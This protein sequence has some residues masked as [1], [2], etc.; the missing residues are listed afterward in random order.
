MLF[1]KKVNLNWGNCP[2]NPKISNSRYR[3]VSMLLFSSFRSSITIGSELS[4]VCFVLRTGADG[5]FELRT[6]ADGWFELRTGVDG[7]FELRT[8][9]DG[10]FELMTGVVGLLDAEDLGSWFLDWLVW[11]VL[12]SKNYIWLR[13]CKSNFKWPF[14]QSWQ[15]KFTTVPLKALSDQ[16]W[17]K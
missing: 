6:G 12:T 3:P 5:W 7:W 4:A 15:C 10:W 11:L 9:V 14:M 13:D 2:L 17:I 16:V 8:G 1:C